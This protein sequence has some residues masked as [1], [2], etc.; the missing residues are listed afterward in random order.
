MI[1]EHPRW[2]IPAKKRTGQHNDKTSFTYLPQFVCRMAML[3]FTCA[4]RTSSRA[5]MSVVLL[6]CGLT[7]GQ[8]RST[9]LPC[10]PS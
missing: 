2:R 10:A 3:M 8:E 5:Y 4:V 9:A 6:D 7:D 1:S